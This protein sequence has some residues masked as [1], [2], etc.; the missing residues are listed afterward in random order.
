MEKLNQGIKLLL[1]TG[2]KELSVKEAISLLRVLT[3]NPDVIRETIK[4][5]EKRGILHR[6]KGKFIIK[7][8]PS[9]KVDI[10]IKKQKC[11]ENCKRCGKKITNCF[12][13]DLGDFIVGPFGSGCIRKILPSYRLI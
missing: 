10:R 3:K 4:L 8:S 11:L 2:K 9:I 7:E 12:Y 5:A 6:E 1:A 13:I